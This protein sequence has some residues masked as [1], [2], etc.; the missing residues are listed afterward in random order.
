MPVTTILGADIAPRLKEILAVMDT[1][2]RLADG[3]YSQTHDASRLARAALAD[4]IAE[5]SE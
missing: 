1:A 2:A 4:L 3:G 5:V